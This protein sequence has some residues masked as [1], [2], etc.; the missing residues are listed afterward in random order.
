MS[1]TEAKLCRKPS[2]SMENQKIQKLAL[3]KI[4]QVVK[5]LIRPI[6]EIREEPLKDRQYML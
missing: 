3:W 4:N 6:K 1:R 2:F 5:S